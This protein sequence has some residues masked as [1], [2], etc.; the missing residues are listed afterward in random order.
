MIKLPGWRHVFGCGFR[1]NIARIVGL[2]NRSYSGKYSHT[3]KASSLTFAEFLTSHF[4]AQ[5]AV[6]EETWS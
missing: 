6:I 1:C 4:C 5:I 2:C 3:S